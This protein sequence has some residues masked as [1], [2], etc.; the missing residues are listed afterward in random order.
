MLVDVENLSSDVGNIHILPL[1]SSFAYLMEEVVVLERGFKPIDS[2]G[3]FRKDSERGVRF[4][5]FL[6]CEIRKCH[7]RLISQRT[8]AHC[9]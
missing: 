7:K 3:R 1:W 5:P 6:Q 8:V 9:G 2:G 4:K